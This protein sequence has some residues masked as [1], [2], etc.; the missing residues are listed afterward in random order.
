MQEKEI[1]TITHYYGHLNVGII[2]L[3]DS[4]KVGE[5]I[6]IKGHASDFTQQVESI[7]VEHKDVGEGKAGDMVGIKVASKVH[8]H[9][10]VYLQ[11]A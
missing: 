10:K 5:T 6:H 2:K 11:S 1:G 8:E 7:Q 9:D 4:L 3:S